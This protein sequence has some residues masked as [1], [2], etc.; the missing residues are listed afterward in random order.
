MALFLESLA[1]IAN[2][3]VSIATL[4]APAAAGLGALPRA[5]PLRA[6][7]LGASTK[8]P[9]LRPSFIASQRT[10]DRLALAAAAKAQSQSQYVVV[11]GPKVRKLPDRLAHAHFY[12]AEPPLPAKSRCPCSSPFTPVL[13]G[14][15]ELSSAA[16]APSHAQ[17]CQM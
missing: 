10:E 9:F 15:G 3:G 6:L 11:T 1:H 4:L 5:G 7:V 17:H 8:L 16:N 2:I 12:A 14:I 13:Q